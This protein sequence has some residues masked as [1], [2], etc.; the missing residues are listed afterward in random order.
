MS[1]SNDS[2]SVTLKPGM[3]SIPH[4]N[5]VTFRV[6]APFADAVS[7]VGSFNDWDEGGHPL[8]EEGDG[9][10]A[11]H[12]ADAKPGDEYKY[13]IRSGKDLMYRLDPYGRQA[14]NSVG[15]SVIDDPTFDWGDDES[16]KIPPWNELVIYE[17]HIGTFNPDQKDG[18]PGTFA[19]A[20]DKLPYLRELGINAIEIMPPMEFPGGVSWG[21]N[22]ALPFAVESDYGGPQAFKSFVKAAH[23]HGIA[24]LLDVVYNHFGPDD[25][26]LWRF[27]GWHENGYGGIYFFNDERANTPWGDT[28][29]DYARPEVRQYLRDNA[30]MWLHEYH[31]DGLRWD[32]TAYIRNVDGTNMDPEKELPD[33]WSF[34]QWIHEEMAQFAPEKLSIAE[35]LKNNEWLVKDTGAGGAGFGSQWDKSFVDPVRSAIIAQEDNGRHLAAVAGA[36]QGKYNGDAFKRV[37]Y[38]ESHDEVANGRAR[39]TEEIW[40]G[41]SL[42]FFAKKRSTLGA[43]LVFTAPGIPMIFQG[44]EFLEDRWFD[45]QDPLDWQQ[46]QEQE[47][48]V[49]L[50]RDL[51]HLRRNWDGLSKGLTGQNINVY[52]LNGEDKVLAYHRWAEGGPGDS[53]VVILNFRNR[54]ICD[55][56]VG[57]PA[58]GRWQLRFDSHY[59]GYDDAFEDQVSGAIDVVEEERDGQ[60]CSAR[61]AVAPYSAVIYSLAE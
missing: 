7:V 12:V 34:M 21:Y 39:V 9:Y 17:M 14:T 37:I 50:Y 25:L 42:H 19:S 24:V 49:H 32:G 27:D 22:P 8:Q 28:R 2:S 4:E 59:G 51:I 58:P 5:G 6:W 57:F 10:W 30:L 46:A 36:L 52:H 40:P 26:D 45:D 29:P 15:N 53:V 47:G 13:A 31:V 11:T 44:Q 20:K 56:Q 43:V 60:C 38:T 33:G 1:H 18:R 41:N 16:F 55:Y 35:D 23:E 54:P 61:V 3:G 48:F